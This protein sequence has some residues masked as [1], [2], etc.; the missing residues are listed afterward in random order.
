MDNYSSM[1]LLK[2]SQGGTV[3]RKPM[4]FTPSQQKYMFAPFSLGH[5][6]SPFLPYNTFLLTLVF[7]YSIAEFL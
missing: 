4:H 6:F 1:A 7:L 3:S 5:N 2:G